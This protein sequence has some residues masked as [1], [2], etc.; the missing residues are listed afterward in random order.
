MEI[1]AH[2]DAN[3]WGPLDDDEDGRL[4]L[5]VHVDQ[6]THSYQVGAVNPA[7]GLEVV[8]IFEAFGPRF[9]VCSRRDG[10][11]VVHEV[12]LETDDVVR[13]ELFG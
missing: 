2:V 8:A 10:A 13:M 3:Y 5:L 12:T 1:R 4:Y 11:T 6:A 9:Y 7:N